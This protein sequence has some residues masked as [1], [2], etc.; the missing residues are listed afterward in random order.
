MIDQ[1]S[2]SRFSTGVP[3]RAIRLSA[4]IDRTLCAVRAAL[5]FTCCASSRT[6]RRQRTP[7]SNSTS[8]AAR[9]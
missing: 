2:L 5:F 7:D 8:R 9:P 4:G 6:R 3:V 1:S